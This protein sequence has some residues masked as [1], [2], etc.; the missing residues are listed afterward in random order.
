MNKKN[1]YYIAILV[2]LAS[3]L[4]V[5][6][7][8]GTLTAKEKRIDSEI[9]IRLANL[10]SIQE[11]IAENIK[12]IKNIELPVLRYGYSYNENDGYF[13][14]EIVNASKKY[15]IKLRY[16]KLIHI[17]KN[18]NTA[19]YLFK[20]SGWGKPADIYS[21]IKTL[22]YNYKIELKK[23]Y[24]SKNFNEAKDVSF[25][26]LLAAYVINKHEILPGILK[27]KANILRPY[28]FGSINPFV[29][30]PEKKETVE[31]IE[32]KPAKKIK[33]AE[34]VYKK[35]SNESNVKKS[36][37]YNKKGVMFFEKNNL[38]KALEMFKK[39]ALLN[40]DNYMALSNAALDS[41]EAK[42]YNKSVFY[43]K[44]ALSKR[45][46]WQINFILG[47]AYLRSKKFS[48]AEYNFKE[49]LKL[50]PS[51]RRIKYYLNISKNRR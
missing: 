28:S 40:P 5:F 49:A 4:G 45:R 25:S 23:F 10:K 9:N 20:V 47:L 26:S 19:V 39:A 13:I 43:A 1:I 21:L 14:S 48:E 17:N 15:G 12:G 32:M 38:A 22:E 41:Y 27:I 16:A 8:Y 29:N 18:K 37:F 11:H 3:A 6:L 30:S 33:I 51:N 7:I 44:K 24:I 2:F 36:D 31:K 42:N 50:N 46:M 34:N 35:L